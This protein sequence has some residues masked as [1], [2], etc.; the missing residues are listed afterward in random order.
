MKATFKNQAALNAAIALGTFRGKAIHVLAL[1]DD[2]CTPSRCM[3]EPEFVVEEL[4]QENLI[5][6]ARAQEAWIRSKQS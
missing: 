4:T 2:S 5:S 3:C 1:H 6:G